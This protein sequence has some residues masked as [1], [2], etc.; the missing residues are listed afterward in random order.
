MTVSEHSSATFDLDLPRNLRV[1]IVAP[2]PDDEVFAVGGLMAVL[3]SRGC[4]LEVI[5]VT[6]GE[7]S[8]ARSRRIT[9]EELRVTRSRET[10]HAYGLLGISPEIHRLELPDSGVARHG[11]ALRSALRSRLRNV[12]LCIAPIETDG[13]PDHDA[14]GSAARDVCAEL[15]VPLWRY[16][17]WSR[18][19]PERPLPATPSIVQLPAAVLAK[20]RLAI[21]AYESQLHALG[22]E[23]EDGPVLPA[24]FLDHFSEQGEPLWPVM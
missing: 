23:P 21:R 20:K 1:A 5:A 13:H 12:G 8:H 9:P 7:A 24:G 2:H 19:H 10:L 16:A 18:L 6:D 17:V 22:P 11:D 15:S 14:C 3:E 4:V